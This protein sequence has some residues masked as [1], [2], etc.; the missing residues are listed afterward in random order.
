MLSCRAAGERPCMPVWWSGE[1][2]LALECEEALQTVLASMKL[3]SMSISISHIV[4]PV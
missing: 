3:V 2:E 1:V 4:V